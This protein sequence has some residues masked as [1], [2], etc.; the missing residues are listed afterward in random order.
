MLNEIDFKAVIKN[1]PLIS[2][3]LILKDDK[4]RVLFGKR[5]NEPAKGSWFVP[6]GRIWKNESIDSAIKRISSS[7]VGIALS[8][9]DFNFQGVYEH[10]YNSNFFSD[11]FETHYVV[12]AYQLNTPFK[13]AS[14]LP[15]S[16]HSHYEFFSKHDALES[17]NIH[18][19]CLPYF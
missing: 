16:Q 5:T 13:G 8:I 9:E 19:N 12:L 14:S 17:D 4:N 2:I 1:A 10:F 6:G 7:E 18:K 3:D 15:K 11:D